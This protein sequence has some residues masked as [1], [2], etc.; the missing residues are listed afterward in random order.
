MGRRD[1]RVD[2]YIERQADFARPILSRLREI[3]HA[4]CPD[5]EETI[6]WGM[7][8]FD[9]HG[10]LCGI[11]GFKRHAALGFWKSALILDPKGNRA[12]ESMGQFGRITKLSDLPPRKVLVGYV[13]KAM[14][15]NE[16]GVKVA[17][18]RT[19][20]RKPLP[21][22]ADLRVALAKSARARATFEKLP[23]GG[24]REYQA[25]I[26]EAKRPETRGRR[27]KTAIQW[28][29]AGKPYDW[30]YKKSAR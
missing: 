29:A 22:P 21:M 2:A 1:P 19:G 24:R 18:R 5:V 10:L 16:Q 7:P 28:L 9:Y 14:E 15:L 25:W 3:V 13:R 27:V 6:K 4:A 26:L 30:K 17:T 23:P 8:S 11:A 20:P 12:D